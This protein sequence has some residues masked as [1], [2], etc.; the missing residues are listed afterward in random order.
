MPTAQDHMVALHAAMEHIPADL[1]TAHLPHTAK[2]RSRTTHI[3]INP[4]HD[5]EGGIRTVALAPLARLKNVLDTRT[6][7]AESYG[8]GRRDHANRSPP[9]FAANS[10]KCREFGEICR[11]DSAVIGAVSISFWSTSDSER[12]LQPQTEQGIIRSISGNCNFLLTVKIRLGCEPPTS[13]SR[14]RFQVL[15]K[16]VDSCYFLIA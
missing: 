11:L 15:L 14:T 13:W 6:M 8:G 5:G 12:I 3:R 1:H 7:P 2:P 4:N 9:K 10:G 16:S